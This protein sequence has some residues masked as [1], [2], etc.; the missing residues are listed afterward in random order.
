MYIS[1]ESVQNTKSYLSTFLFSSKEYESVHSIF[2]FYDNHQCP[3]PLARYTECH[4]QIIQP[5]PFWTFL[6]MFHV[7]CIWL[8]SPGGSTAVQCIFL[9]EVWATTTYWNGLQ[10]LIEMGFNYSKIVFFKRFVSMVSEI[11]VSVEHWTDIDGN[12][13]FDSC[14]KVN[15]LIVDVDPVFHRDSLCCQRGKVWWDQ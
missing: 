1:L 7:G 9:I 5:P 4:I 13:R 12:L 15:N 8:F 11:G 6:P 14:C 3:S 10:L 2:F